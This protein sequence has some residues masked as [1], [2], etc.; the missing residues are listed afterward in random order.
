MT[1]RTKQPGRYR[2]PFQVLDRDGRLALVRFRVDSA[3]HLRIRDQAACGSC[4]EK[5]C[6]HLCP[7][8]NYTVESEG[9]VQLSWVGCLECGT[10]RIICP[11]ANIEW[12]YPRGGF[13][14]AYRFG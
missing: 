4:P 5:P 13:G 10:C 14:V 9:S 1:S 3:A 2:K 8:H 11:A 7:A 12:T 6:T